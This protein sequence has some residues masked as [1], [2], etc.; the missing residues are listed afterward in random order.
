M[1][2]VQIRAGNGYDLLVSNLPWYSGTRFEVCMST[3]KG[4]HED[5]VLR[6]LDCGSQ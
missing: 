3:D 2:K 6:P 4:V 5:P 1:T